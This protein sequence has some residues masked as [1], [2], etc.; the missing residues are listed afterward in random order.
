MDPTRR[1]EIRQFAPLAAEDK[2]I[3]AADIFV[4]DPSDTQLRS[5][6]RGRFQ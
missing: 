4:A 6:R 3:H 2:S 5:A 1:L